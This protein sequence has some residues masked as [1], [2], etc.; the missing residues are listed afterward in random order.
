M[1]RFYQDSS[2][3]V[4][5]GNAYHGKQAI[6]EFFRQLPPSTHMVESL[7]CHPIAPGK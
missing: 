2:V 5:N 4:W 1:H 3:V 6:I 7:D